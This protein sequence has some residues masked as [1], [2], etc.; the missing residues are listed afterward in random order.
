MDNLENIKR[1][2][3]TIR[4]QSRLEKTEDG[5]LKF[6]PEDS[7]MLMKSVI[8][9]PEDHQKEKLRIAIK[10]VFGLD[11]KDIVIF[12][13]NSIF[14]KKWGGT[15]ILYHEIVDK[16]RDAFSRE[17]SKENGS[18]E[19]PMIS[20][21]ISISTEGLFEELGISASDLT[22]ES[23]EKIKQK[24][25]EQIMLSDKDAILFLNDK[26]VIRRFK[27]QEGDER[28]GEQHYNSLPKEELAIL[29]NSIFASQETEQ[30]IVSDITSQILETELNFAHITHEYFAKNYIRIFQNAIF[31]F[32]KENLSEEDIVLEGLA[33]LILRE[34]W[35]L[36]HTKMAIA[37][38]NLVAKKNQ[39]AENFLKNYSGEIELDSKRNK[40]KLPEILDRNGNK[41]NISSIVGIVMQRK[42]LLDSFSLKQKAI[43]ELMTHIEGL[44]AKIDELNK[45]EINIK[46]EIESIEYESKKIASIEAA[47]NAEIKELREML[48]RCKDEDAKKIQGE[49]SNKMLFLKKLI[50]QEDGYFTK[51]KQLEHQ[52]KN[53][54]GKIEKINFDINKLQKKLK[55][56]EEKN[57]QFI[58]SQKGLSEKFKLLSE[59]LT[60]ALMKKKVKL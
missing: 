58:S 6:S 18:S 8:N 1:L 11:N 47:T 10:E 54:A 49:I 39:N 31:S 28:K 14:I 42:K 7:E 15:P 24:L 30:E 56:E 13:Q 51:Q 52:Q 12:R 37:I 38:L 21:C 25:K 34:N 22:A 45:E 57:A 44:Y 55:E 5:L 16:I 35:I 3:S 40:Y 48:K 59:A 33:N 41:W 27:L 23:K 20:D 32:L 43:D 19:I 17:N 4:D 36:I 60:L 9:M 53:I 26:V 50:V 2:I 29:K 46:K